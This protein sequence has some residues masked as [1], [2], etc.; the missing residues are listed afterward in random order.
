MN[1]EKDVPLTV[2]E[3]FFNQCFKA[4]LIP[5]TSYEK[6]FTASCRRSRER[7]D[8]LLSYLDI[9]GWRRVSRLHSTSMVVEAMADP[10]PVLS[11][12][13]TAQATSL[14][15]LQKPICHHL[16]LQDKRLCPQVR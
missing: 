1:Q 6:W 13:L 8:S 11:V 10:C 12:S 2:V 15:L 9:Q 14:I 4:P 16:E 3:S 7:V 5:T